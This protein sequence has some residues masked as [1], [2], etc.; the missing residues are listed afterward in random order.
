[1]DRIPQEL[2][3]SGRPSNTADYSTLHR[4]GFFLHV[5]RYVYH[6]HGD[7]LLRRKGARESSS[8]PLVL[9]VLLVFSPPSLL[10]RP[11]LSSSSSS[12]RPPRS[13]ARSVA[14]SARPIL[15]ANLSFSPRAVFS[16][17]ARAI[18][19]QLFRYFN[20]QGR[21]AVSLTRDIYTYIYPPPPPPSLPPSAP[22]QPPSSN[23]RLIASTG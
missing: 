15:P 13:V 18:S 11:P 3:A 6:R 16:I 2:T 21:R 19:R 8:R 22:F 1:M 7:R 5:T 17:G 20:F 14:L 9:P 10:S 23:P 12:S 4:F